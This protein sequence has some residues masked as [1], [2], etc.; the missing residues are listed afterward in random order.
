MSS[1]PEEDLRREN[2]DLRA[3]LRDLRHRLREPEEI[4]RALRHG[5]VDALVVNEER[6]ERIYALRS[7]NVLYRA[8]IEDMKEAAVALDRNGI[9]VY[10]NAYF[11]ELMKADRSAI[12]GTSIFPSVPDESRHFFLPL[13]HAS[14]GVA[15]REE[16]ALRTKDGDL[17][18]V[19]ATLNPI[20]VEEHDVFCLILTSLAGQKR[21]EELLVESRRKDEFLA[22]LAHELRNP[23]APIRNAAHMLAL[24]DSAE[25]RLKWAREV[26]DRQVVHMT[27]LVDDLLDVS[28][29]TRGKIRLD[30]EPT[31]LGLVIS[32]SI[33][34]SRPVIEAQ[35]H[36]LIVDLSPD[37]LPVHADM[38]RLSQAISNLLNNAA[39]FTPEGGRIWLK[40]E[41]QDGSAVVSVRDSGI[42]IAPDMLPRIFD[43][44]TQAD[45][46]R[47]RAQG[48]L[49]IGLTLVRTL[50]EMH[51]GTVEAKSAGLGQGTEFVI[52]LPIRENDRVRGAAEAQERRPRSAVATPTTPR[53]IVIVED[54]ADS[55]ETLMVLLTE[56]GHDVRT[57]NNAETAV[58]VARRFHPELMLVDIGLPGVN[59]HELARRLRRTPGLE[60]VVLVAVTGYGR[61]EDR[62]ASLEAG[63]D[64]HWVKPI[65]LA[66]LS[67]IGP[68]SGDRS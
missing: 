41:R 14:N 30:A 51:G 27:R 34:T 47:E 38:T 5:E 8:M 15:S 9:V 7:A 42:G 52:R 50:V 65:D 58:E 62:R 17:V 45:S 26:I 37:A 20:Q 57:A 40:A 12:V 43:M 4:I 32:R 3:R 39:K 63:F 53:R 59:G 56:L 44:F 33:E 31:D 54:N 2:A 60:S 67:R 36:R 18:P 49:G 35:R 11:A 24:T 13:K 64:E 61:A 55:S 25:P 48:G 10:C 23:I 16:I 22:M 1:P 28:R 29:I 46:T 6:G 66:A 21:E 68:L 19:F